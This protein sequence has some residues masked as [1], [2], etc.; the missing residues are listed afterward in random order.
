MN[1]MMNLVELNHISKSF[2]SVK[3]LCDVSFAIQKGTVHA[4]MGENGAGKST[5]IKILAGV[6]SPDPGAK[7]R[8]DG[9]DVSA[10]NPLEAVRRGIA[11]TYQDFSLFP[12]LTVV[13]NIAVSGEIEKNRTVVHWKEMRKAAKK[14]VERMGVPIDLDAQLGALSAAKQQLVAIARALVYDAKLLILDE[15]T[16]TLSASEVQSLFS[17]I[18]KLKEEGMAILFI[19][20]KIDEVFA[21]SDQITVLR[22]GTY[23]GTFDKKQVSADDIIAYMVGRKVQYDRKAPKK[24]SGE[25]ILEI[26]S[27]SKKGNYADISF[28]LKKGEILAL[29]G[30]VGAGRTELCQS[31]Y[32]ITRPDS[33]SILFEGREVFVKNAEQANGLGIAFVPEDRRVQ[34]LVTRRNVRENITLSVLHTLTNRIKLVDGKKEDKLAAQFIEKLKIKPPIPSLQV[35]NLSG[36]NQ[37]RVVLAKC[38]AL[39]PKVLIIDE[40]TN[41]I[42][43]GAKQEIHDLLRELAEQ[44]MGII[45]ISSE[46]PE[47]LAISNRVLVMRRGRIVAEFDGDEATQSAIMHKAIL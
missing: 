10:L 21:I 38:L 12:N 47:V 15:P 13:E 39:H 33:G 1:Q 29:T 35:G 32:G 41:G 4:L 26:R 43:I 40:P 42:D 5:L 44:G 2:A 45:M 24:G 25:T 36:G 27:L 22:D 34:G 6:Y 3:A 46:L 18:Q 37:Q 28:R 14:A 20:H 16:S 31:I 23:I 30:L 7:I 17:I 9:Q 11:V 8:I 19:S